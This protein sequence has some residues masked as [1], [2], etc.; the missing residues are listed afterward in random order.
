MNKQINTSTVAAIANHVKV[1]KRK[2]NPMTSLVDSGY[3]DAPM[4][5]NGTVDDWKN[6]FTVAQRELFDQMYSQRIPKES[7]MGRFLNAHIFN[8]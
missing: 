6:Y 3:C 5:R 2:A 7:E 8:R 4:Q 1:E